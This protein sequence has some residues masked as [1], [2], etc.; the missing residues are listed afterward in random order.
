MKASKIRNFL[1]DNPHV[2]EMF[3]RE[4]MR[5]WYKGFQHYSARTI[6]HYLRH[7]T[8]MEADPCGYF[9][10]NNNLS[11]TLAR[12]FLEKHPEIPVEFFETRKADV[13]KMFK[14]EG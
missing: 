5:V 8:A 11:P 13:E 1:D 12:D 9:K 4:A 6:I 10:V 2:F 14:L 3:E 7:M